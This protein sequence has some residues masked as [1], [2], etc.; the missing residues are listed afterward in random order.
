MSHTGVKEEGI[1]ESQK[2]MEVWEGFEEQLLFKRWRNLQEMK[3][4]LT[5]IQQGN[6]DI[7]TTATSDWMLSTIWM[8]LKADSSLEPLDKGSVQPSPYLDFDL[9]SREPREPAWTYDT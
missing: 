4:T 1:R 8:N 5:D 2:I 9:I 6:R 7:R 3:A